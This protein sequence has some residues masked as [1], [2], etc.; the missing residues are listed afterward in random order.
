MKIKLIK[1]NRLLEDKKVFK[2][3]L[4]I[5]KKEYRPLDPG[6]YLY[7]LLLDKRKNEDIFSDSY[8]ELI[9]TTL[10]AW[11]MDGRGAKLEE[12]NIFKNSIRENK[13]DII[14]LRKFKLS[15]LDQ[16]EKEKSLEILKKLFCNLKLTQ[17]KSKLVTFSKTLHFLLPE[18]IVPID[19]KYT[20]DFFY[21]N[22]MLPTSK[23]DKE[24]CEKQFYIFRE[25]F[26]KFFELSQRYNLDEYL[27]KSWSIVPTK[28]LDNAIIGYCKMGD[29]GEK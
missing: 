4:E 7:N 14:Q 12:I 6:L 9:Y 20:L 8:L 25:L 28:V 10:I 29:D 3:S 5:T 13:E 24:N 17:T 22:G 18:L 23:E 21:G 1:F 19:R 26:E 27:D 15:T 11:N 2:D 16:I